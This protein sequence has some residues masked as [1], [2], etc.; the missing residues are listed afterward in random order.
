MRSLAPRGSKEFV[1]SDIDYRSIRDRVYDLS[2]ISLG[3]RKVDLVYSRLSKRLRAHG[4][5]SFSSYLA[6]LDSP[7]G[8]PEVEHMLNALTT[9]LTSFFREPHHFDHL[10]TVALESALSR[11][12]SADRRLRLWSTACSTGEEPYSIAMT[13]LD[14]KTDLAG[15]DMRILAT[16][17]NTDVLRQAAAGRYSA[18]IMAKCPA[19]ARQ[20]FSLDHDGAGQARASLRDL[21]SF[22]HLNLLY[23]W[24]MKGLFDVV[25]CRNVLIYFDSET[26]QRLVNR[27]VDIL[28]PGGWLYLGHS[29]SASGSHPG[30]GAHRSNDLP[31]DPMTNLRAKA[32]FRHRQDPDRAMPGA[33]SGAYFDSRFGMNVVVVLPGRHYVTGKTDEMI[34]TLLGSCVAACIRDPV[35]A[36]GG[37]NHFLLPASESGVWESTADAAMRYGNHA[38]ET[39]INDIIKLGGLRSRLEVKV[40]GGAR[41]IKGATTLSVGQKNIEFVQRYLENEGLEIAAHH[42]GGV[43]ARRI[44]YFPITGKVQM[45]QLQRR[46]DH[47]LFKREMT[48]LHQ[49]E[50]DDNAGDAELFD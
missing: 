29:E 18:T 12:T 20:H 35:A 33:E 5:T 24:P 22:R 2:G 10:G 34:V 45:R 15:V 11:Q 25:F 13:L 4:L 36:V 19:S 17:L 9:N 14:S 27:F 30:P 1:F 16:D 3:D 41:V 28:K 43:Q 26:K 47:Q 40:F 42:L 46:T 37:L 23:P 49:I 44:Q 32:L 31:E 38:M 39:L 48:Y 7:G 6:L 50:A 8:G 21:I